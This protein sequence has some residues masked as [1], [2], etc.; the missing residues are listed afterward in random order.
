MLTQV[1]SA[2]Y[3]VVTVQPYNHEPPPEYTFIRLYDLSYR[4][5]IGGQT[6]L[7]D[8]LQLVGLYGEMQRLLAVTR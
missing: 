5:R 4:P 8:V 2:S 1:I 7:P 6:F 3:A